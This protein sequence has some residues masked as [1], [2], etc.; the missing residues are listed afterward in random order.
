MQHIF[1]QLNK[2]CI[3]QHRY[4]FSSSSMALALCSLSEEHMYRLCFHLFYLVLR[5]LKS[6]RRNRV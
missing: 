6:S 3:P 4:P 1:K 2:Y 5:L